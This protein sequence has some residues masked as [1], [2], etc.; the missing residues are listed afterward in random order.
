M[1]E[2]D[3]EHSLK[4]LKDSLVDIIIITGTTLGVLVFVI[5][6]IPFHPDLI[7]KDFG[8]DLT[9]VSTL[10]LTYFFRKKLS[11]HFKANVVI[12]MAYIIFLSDLIESG[13]YTQ[14]LILV[15]IIPFLSILVYNLRV[16]IILYAVC[17]SSVLIVGLLFKDGII[18]SAIYDYSDV[19]YL[20]WVETALMSTVVIFIITLF[21][22]RFDKKI[23]SLFK[24]LQTKNEFLS[25]REFLLTTI[26][27]NF[28]RSYMSVIDS[29]FI[30]KMTGGS[31]FSAQGLD[32]NQF[33]GK[34]VI[35]VYEPF[36]EEPLN[37][38]IEA[39]KKTL[40]GQ[41]QIFQIK[42]GDQYQLYKTMPLPDKNGEINTFLSVV[43]NV[44]EIV[45]TNHLIEEN[46]HEKN[47]LLQEIHHRVKNNL[48]VVSGLLSLQSLNISDPRS[49]FI[50][51][52]STNRIM[53]IAKVHEM[54]YESQNFNR[55]PFNRY[56]NELANI[57]LDSM[58]HDGKLIDIKTD[59]R[60]K[61]ISINHGVPLGII[62]NELIT[63]SVKYGFASPTDNKIQISVYQKD[64]KYVVLYEDNG[65]GIEDF[66][67]AKTNSLGFTLIQSLLHQIE[68]E[69]EYD[70]KERFSL[71][72]SFSTDELA[73]PFELMS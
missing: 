26:T 22:Y 51:E 32:P 73:N 12:L 58:N 8:F 21:L 18:I 27:D 57:I 52:K 25:E 29:D 40:S 54:L 1:G 31:E 16:T 44:T 55:I 39:Y 36:G 42:L 53:S 10:F 5:S 60:V 71:T 61:Y 46:L 70:T 11:V 28:P 14:D 59:I 19:N 72:F 33:N 67:T 64:D 68:A 30:I 17:M 20:R 41:G 13:L 62:F 2:I 37:T 56:I 45:E 4:E 43:E 48:A 7:N 69:Y 34:S 66:K 15:V 3:N 24:D 63:N 47:V 50:L 49:K 9:A 6:M 38:I 65:I 35:D 23:F